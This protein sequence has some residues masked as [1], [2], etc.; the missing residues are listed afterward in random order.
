[1]LDMPELDVRGPQL[2]P[3]EGCTTIG[4]GGYEGFW[5]SSVAVWEVVDDDRIAANPINHRDPTG[6]YST[7]FDGPYLYN[8]AGEVG[9]YFVVHREPGWFDRWVPGMAW[10]GDD[11]GGCTKIRKYRIGD[12][13][14][15]KAKWNPKQFKTIDEGSLAV[16][17]DEI[18]YIVRVQA[19]NGLLHDNADVTMNGFLLMCGMSMGG[20]IKTIGTQVLNPE[21]MP[22]GKG[23]YPAVLKNGRVTIGRFHG[24]AADAAGGNVEGSGWVNVDAA[25]NVTEWTTYTPTS[26]FQTF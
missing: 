9:V 23:P 13:F 1:M 24:S 11:G 12:G 8:D 5:A 19:S 26:G 14:V 20:A 22:L 17:I 18:R 16:Y 6:L 4:H 15:N 3:E 2:P 21:A 7:A 25:G 10:L